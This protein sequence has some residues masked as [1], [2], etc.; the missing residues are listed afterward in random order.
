MQPRQP[1]FRHYST[2]IMTIA[3]EDALRIAGRPDAPAQSRVRPVKGWLVAPGLT[4]EE[5]GCG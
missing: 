3:Y 2:R 1:R 4:P 5:G